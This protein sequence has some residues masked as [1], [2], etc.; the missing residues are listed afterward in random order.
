MFY[1]KV[2]HTLVNICSL[3]HA[4]LYCMHIQSKTYQRKPNTHC[5]VCQKSIYRR[6]SELQRTKSRAYCSNTCYGVACRKEFPCVVC[7]TPILASAKK[8]TCSRRC[9]N[10]H[11]AGLQYKTGRKKDKVH[12]A[13]ILKQE[14]LETRGEGCERCGYAVIAILQIH[15]RDRNKENNTKENLELL[16][17]NC[18]CKEH[19]M[20]N[21]KHGGIG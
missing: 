19:Y 18:H 6:P 14:L 8:K 11:R 17:P 2:F 5:T 1:I 21:E 3:F 10:I 9:A 15:H 4:T 13:R 7:G 20:Q 16:C 12:N